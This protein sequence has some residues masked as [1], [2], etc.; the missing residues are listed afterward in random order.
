MFIAA[1]AIKDL[2]LIQR[3]STGTGF[4]YGNRKSKSNK[5]RTRTLAFNIFATAI[6]VSGALF[7]SCKKGDK[8]DTGA[9]G[10]AG[11]NGVVPTYSDGYIKGTITGTK[12]DGTALNESFEYKNYYS[13]QSGT[14][15]SNS[16]VSYD[17]TIARSSDVFNENMASITVNTTS[18]TATSGNFTLNDFSFKKSPSTNHLFVFTTS[19]SQTT[20]ISGLSYN[21]SSG[22]FTGNYTITVPGFQNSTGNSATIS[23]SFSAT[24][25][26]IHHLI[27]HDTKDFTN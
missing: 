14:L 22:L 21:T 25:T 26:Q 13:G 1:S 5:M 11:T 18:K 16:T 4:A 12:A 10:P 27:K 19:G 9:T 17:F 7:T 15:D 23:G 8:G 2:L 6:I 24:I 20:T 3:V